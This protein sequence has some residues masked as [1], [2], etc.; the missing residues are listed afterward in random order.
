MKRFIYITA[1]IAVALIGV[2][3]F[4]ASMHSAIPYATGITVDEDTVVPF[5]V[6]HTGDPQGIEPRRTGD[7]H[8]PENIKTGVFYDEKTGTYSYGSQ[9]IG[10]QSGAKS[11]EGESNATASASGA[12]LYVPFFMTYDDYESWAMQQSMQ[13]YFKKKNAEEAANA[14]KEKFDFTDMHFDLGPA[15]KIFGP[16]G[17]RVK[18]QGS[19]ELKIGGNLKFV[20]NPTLSERNRKVFGFD[21]DENINLSLNGKVGDKVNLNFNYNSEATFNFD[22]QNLKLRYEGKE[23]EIVKLVE[24]GNVSMPTQSSLIRGANSL[25]GLR[26]DL[27]FGKLTVQTMV[28]QKKSASQTVKSKNGVQTTPFEFSASDYS[29]NRHFFLAHYFR[30][31]YDGWMT[32]LPNILSGVTV[33]R[34]ELLFNLT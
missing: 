7:L 4:A 15:E 28:A 11:S 12:F 1:A 29:E 24:A 27:Q 8:D 20:D 2:A 6:R 5:T 14:G 25:F 10:G 22:T 23:D 26:T 31:N 32:T 30:D 18:T 33:N 21:L 3:A 17:V 13:Q 9:L 19:A 16:G 34:I